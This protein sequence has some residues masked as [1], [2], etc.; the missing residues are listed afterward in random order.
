[1][2]MFILLL[3]IHYFQSTLYHEGEHMYNG[4]V[5]S[6]IG[7]EKASSLNEW[8]AKEEVRAYKLQ[9]NHDSTKSYRGSTLRNE[10]K[11]KIGL[12]GG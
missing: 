3:N 1:M 5:L 7:P 6:L 11:N 10:I 9:L 12:Y 8:H 2:K 4:L